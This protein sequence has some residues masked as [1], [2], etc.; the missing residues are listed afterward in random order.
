MVRPRLKDRAAAVS[1]HPMLK[2]SLARTMHLQLKRIA[3]V[4]PEGAGAMA[5]VIDESGQDL[6]GGVGLGIR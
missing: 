3:M 5:E 2:L 1:L 4:I 6:G